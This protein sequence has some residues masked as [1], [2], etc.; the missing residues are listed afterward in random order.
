MMRFAA[1]AAPYFDSAEIVEMHHTRKLDAPSGTALSTAEL[2]AKARE[3]HGRGPFSEDPTER[4]T[5]PHA[6]GARTEAGVQ[7]HSLRI[8]GTVAHQEVILG[9]AGQTLTLRHDTYD[10]TSFMPGILMGVRS[11]MALDGLVL[12]LDWLFGDLGINVEV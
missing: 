5:L 1:F 2:M 10:R 4:E 12:G 11:V 9:A 6:R 8:H 7:L 3:V